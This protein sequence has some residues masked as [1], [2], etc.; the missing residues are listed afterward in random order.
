M[1]LDSTVISQL[2]EWKDP[3]KTC[4]SLALQESTALLL[5]LLY[6]KLVRLG[7][8]TLG[9]ISL[10]PVFLVLT[11]LPLMLKLDKTA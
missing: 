7:K 5:L 8:I 2:L 3:L 9:L 11:I 1:S 6:L 4:L 10:S